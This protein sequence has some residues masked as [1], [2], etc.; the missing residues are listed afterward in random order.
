MHSY[1]KKSNDYTIINSESS[2][3]HRWVAIT[4][5]LYLRNNAKKV[6]DNAGLYHYAGN[7]PIRYMDPDGRLTRTSEI[8]KIID[9][10]GS[11]PNK[12]IS[13][14][15]SIKFNVSRMKYIGDNQNA[16]YEENDELKI[17]AADNSTMVDSKIINYEITTEKNAELSLGEQLQYAS[18]KH[19]GLNTIVDDRNANKIETTTEKIDI[20]IFTAR[21]IAP[22][23]KE[24]GIY[25]TFIDVNNDGN[26][27]YISWGEVNLDD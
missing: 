2:S 7:N 20:R 3:Y 23:G 11:H 16:I 14:E 6:T 27:D 13:K 4:R 21:S 19:F 24:S 25:K 22:D 9:E 5:Y 12:T 26:I 17:L 10:L 8:Q 15:L 18:K 1:L